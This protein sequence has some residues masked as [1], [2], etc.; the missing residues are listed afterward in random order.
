LPAWSRTA[1]AW[2]KAIDEI[3]R[4]TDAAERHRRFSSHL[5]EFAAR[6]RHIVEQEHLG[7]IVYSGGDDV[8]AFLPLPKALACAQSLRDAFA[9]LMEDACPDFKE[10]PTLSVGLGV[11]HVLESMGD[12]LNLGREAEKLA[13]GGHLPADRRRNALAVIVDKRS[14]GKR[15]WRARWN[16]AQFAKGPARRLMDDADLRGAVSTR[17]VYQIAETLRRFPRPGE[18][19]DDSAVWARMLAD[20]ARRS[21]ERM[22]AGGASLRL[23]DATLKGQLGL[24][25]GR[26][27]APDETLYDARHR[28]VADW[29]DRLLIARVLDEA[30]P[31]PRKPG[32]GV[33]AHAS[34]SAA[35]T[36]TPGVGAS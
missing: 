4:G 19:I 25:L 6:A 24:D 11:G 33:A 15:Q 29:I 34:S 26:A 36:A 28:T 32:G 17:K 1:T 30:Q 5:S 3:S 9:A 18:S 12:L 21:L 27:A 31:V 10:L 22:D 2:A 16:D 20:E 13:K 7:S 35:G 23:D 8:L 14:G